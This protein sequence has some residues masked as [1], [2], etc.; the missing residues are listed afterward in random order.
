MTAEEKIK[1][2]IDIAMK[3]GGIDGGHHKMWVIDQMVRALTEGESEK[4]TDLITKF[5]AGADGPE[6]YEWDTGVAP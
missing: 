2:A 5:C 6:T 4:Y 1:S 3:Y